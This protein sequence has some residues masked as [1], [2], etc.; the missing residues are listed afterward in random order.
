M[1]LATTLSM[2]FMTLIAISN[3]FGQ[4]TVDKCRDC[5]DQLQ[6]RLRIAN[7]KMD[8]VALDEQWKI[9]RWDTILDAAQS[10]LTLRKRELDHWKQMPGSQASQLTVECQ[11][12]IDV[13]VDGIAKLSTRQLQLVEQHRARLITKATKPAV[14]DEVSRGDITIDWINEAVATSKPDE[15]EVVIT[16]TEAMP[17]ETLWVK[18]PSIECPPIQWIIDPCF[19]N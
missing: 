13:T 9:G 16:Q 14:L 10:E 4:S 6:P 5:F 12:R 17:N 7:A 2:M 11:R 15:T 8:K 19:R 3:L 18:C 1:K